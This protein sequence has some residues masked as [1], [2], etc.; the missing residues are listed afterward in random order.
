MRT[1][2]ATKGTLEPFCRLSRRWSYLPCHWDFSIHREAADHFI[3]FFRNQYE[4]TL[5]LAQRQRIAHGED[6]ADV[7]RRA[8]A[9]RKKF[10]AFLDIL[11]ANPAKLGRPT[12]L[13]IDYVRDGVLR[14]AGFHDPFY[15]IKHHDNELVL[16]LLPEVCRDIDAHAEPDRLRAVIDGALAG[17]IFDM[18]VPA[19]AQRMMEKTLSFLHTRDNLPR[20]PWLVDELD[21]FARRMLAGPVHHKAVLFVDNAGADFVL[22]MLP[23]ARYLAGRG[24]EVLIVGNELPTLNDMTLRDMQ[25]I[26][27]E[28]LSAEPSLARLP[29]RLLSSGTGAPLID[30]SAVSPELNRAAADADLVILQGMGRA[31]ESNFFTRFDCDVLKI[32]MVKEEYVATW[33]GGKLYDVACRFEPAQG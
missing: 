22:G 9:C 13:T 6:A 26:W 12:F 1:Q 15:E 16:Q 31:L 19:T 24:T 32:A 29:I 28:I 27:P 20:R 17:N 5:M 8:V 11:Q 21:I 10:N 23:L 33:L 30:L 25:E 4:R 3:Q 14:Y 18:G 7:S 2:A